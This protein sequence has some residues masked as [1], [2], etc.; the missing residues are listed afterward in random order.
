MPDDPMRRRRKTLWTVGAIA[1]GV[2]L[3]VSAAASPELKPWVRPVVGMLMIACGLVLSSPFA[4]SRPANEQQ[5]TARRQITVL[6]AAVVVLGVAQVM[7]R[8]AVSLVL[9]GVALLLVASAG[10]KWPRRVFASR[11]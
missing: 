1:L 5:A 4:T 11:L 10:T 2:G 9:T 6:G 3:V 8:A 7:P